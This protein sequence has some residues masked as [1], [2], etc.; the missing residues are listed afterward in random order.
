[1]AVTGLARVLMAEQELALC[2]ISDVPAE[3]GFRRELPGDVTVA[4]FRSGDEYFVVDDLCTH[5]SASLADGEVMGE[6]IA[7]PYHFGTFSLRTGEPTGAPCTM[8][9]R[10]Y[11]ATVRDGVIYIADPSA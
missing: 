3:G 8:P 4:V 2:N 10:T 11:P 5:G 7:C 6:D 9:L 1:M